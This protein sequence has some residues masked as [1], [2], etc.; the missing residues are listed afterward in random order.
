[1]LQ[2]DFEAALALE[3]NGTPAPRLTVRLDIPHVTNEQEFLRHVVQEAVK[4]F[5][6]SDLHQ[7][8][9]APS[10]SALSDEARYERRRTL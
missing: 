2:K 8:E 3:L 10:E 7:R 4:V 6:R 1:M 5:R 9:S